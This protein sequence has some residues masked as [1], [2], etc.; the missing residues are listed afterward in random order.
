MFV[1]KILNFLYLLYNLHIFIKKYEGNMNIFIVKLFTSNTYES[2]YNA[3]DYCFEKNRVA[4]G[5]GLQ[6]NMI[7]G[8]ET[9]EELVQMNINY[10]YKYCKESL[11]RFKTALKN[12]KDK[13]KKGDFIWTQNNDGRNFRLGKVT[14]DAPFIDKDNLL[15]GLSRH[16]EWH[17][18]DYNDV[19]GEIIN[20]YQRRTITLFM[21]HNLHD[22]E[23]YFNYLYS[24]DCSLNKRLNYKQLLHYD[25]LEDLLG[26]YLQ[27]HKDFQY[28]LFP[29]SNKISTKLIE[30]ELR[31]EKNGKIEKACVQCKTGDSIV[32]ESFF[33]LNE[34]KDYRI[35]ISTMKNDNYDKKGKNVKTIFT[36]ELW[37]W[38]K[39]NKNLL[40]GRIQ[41][42]IEICE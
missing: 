24:G 35:Y 4:I 19:P 36:D 31:R 2:E 37:E 38:A 21:K 12:I 26:I 9:P 42:Y 1:Q 39:N 32:D 25:D 33:K 11:S 28:Y 40:P 8:K 6:E 41:K 34:F 29:S 5:W 7:N 3:Q 13:M 18:I 16:C 20:S 30:Y 17:T 27:K 15:I 14:D 23:E 10:N 22:F